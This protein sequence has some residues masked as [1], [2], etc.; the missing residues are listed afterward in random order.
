MTTVFRCC[1][2]AGLFTGWW[3][4]SMAQPLQNEAIRQELA[5]VRHLMQQKAYLDAKWVTQKLK[6]NL[7]TDSRYQDTINY[8]MGWN[9]YRLRNLDS[10]PQYLNQVTSPP[11]LQQKSLFYSSL[12]NAYGFHFEAARSSLANIPLGQDPKLAG[13]H[14]LQKAG[15][16]L[17]QRDTAQFRRLSQNFTD[18]SFTYVSQQNNFLKYYNKIKERKAKSAFLSGLY[19]ALIPGMGKMYLGKKGEAI[20]SFLLTSIFAGLTYENY[21]RLGI[22]NGQTIIF[23]G[24]FSVVYIGNIWGSVIKTKIRQDEFNFYMNEQ[25]L[26]DMHLALRTY[27]D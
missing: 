15:L 19:S 14:N 11:V 3:V 10:V 25:I 9:H 27:Y 12:A 24:I 16:A 13:L 23:G 8:L 26:V 7:G 6:T 20:S 21:R 5:F 22:Q 1:L 2:W 18:A 4:N 17:L